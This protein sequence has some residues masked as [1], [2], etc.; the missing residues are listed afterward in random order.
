M[1]VGL[2]GP[3]A[4]NRMAWGFLILGP[5]TEYPLHRCEVE[6]VYS[7]LTGQ[8]LWRQDHRDW[9][10]RPSGL[11]VYHAVRG[12]HGMR[13]EMTPLLARYLWRTGNL[14]QK[15]HIE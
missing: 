15:S 8:T 4:N 9:A 7:P 12:P 14:I 1:F 5:R 11:P 13:T 6:E 10:H 3:V 2:R